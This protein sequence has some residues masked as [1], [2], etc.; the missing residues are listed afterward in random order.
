MTDGREAA[1]P[2]LEA[3]CVPAYERKLKL[4]EH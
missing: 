3:P 2:A 1:E 4:L